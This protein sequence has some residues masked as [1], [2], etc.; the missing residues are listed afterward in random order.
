MRALVQRVSKA[1]V[2]I[3]QKTMAAIHNGLLVFLGIEEADGPDDSEWLAGKLVR[4]RIFPDDQGQM[5]RSI[6]EVDAEMLVISQFTL[7][8]ST[9]KGNRPSFVRAAKPAT[10]I[11]KYE[12]FLSRLEKEL[13]KTVAK[14]Q[15][16]ADM[17]VS[18][19]ND[20]PVTLWIDSQRRE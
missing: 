12:E 16:G 3:Q 11:P 2:T 5:N 1:S 19:V 7:F 9:K 20:G 14:G 4:L 6:L 17:Q 15:F 10:A 8:A 18:L 13:G